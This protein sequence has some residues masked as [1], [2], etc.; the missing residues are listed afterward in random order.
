MKSLKLSVGYLL[1][2]ED[3]E[4]TREA[5]RSYLQARMDDFR[6]DETELL[7][8]VQ[9]FAQDLGGELDP[10]SL[11]AK[12]RLIQHLFGWGAAKKATKIVA[13]VK[14]AANVRRER[15]RGSAH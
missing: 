6:P 2:I 7:A 12:Y 5:A 9:A 15:L 8:E 13:A 14:L 1:R 11:G 4:R 3:S 10:P